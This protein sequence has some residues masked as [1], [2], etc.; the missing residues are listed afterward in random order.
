MIRIMFSLGLGCTG[1]GLKNTLSAFDTDCNADISFADFL[2]FMKDKFMEAFKVFD[3]DADGFINATELQH[4]LEAFGE[5]FEESEVTS[6]IAKVD[7]KG[8]G[9]IDFEEFVMFMIQEP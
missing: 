9:Q 5:N 2:V 3:H 8:D 6:M 4:Q 7:V 1:A